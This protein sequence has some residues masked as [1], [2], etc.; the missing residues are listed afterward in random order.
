MECAQLEHLL[1]LAV[2]A[3]RVGLRFVHGHLSDLGQTCYDAEV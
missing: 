2:V 3:V 1:V